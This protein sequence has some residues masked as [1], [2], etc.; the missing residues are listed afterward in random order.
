M[1]VFIRKETKNDIS[2]INQLNREAFGGE[3]EPKL[4]KLLRKRNELLVSL[5]AFDGDTVVGHTCASPVKIDG[6]DCSVAGIG[7]LAVIESHRCRGIGAMLMEEII[8]KLRATGITA[9]VLLGNPSYYPRFGFIS[10]TQFDLQNEYGASDA[11]MAIELKED[12]LNNISG[13]VQ[14]VAAFAECDA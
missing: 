11:F 2:A 1:T 6:E 4:V 12:A 5:V 9:A 7:P 14:Y 8:S 10:G 3:V 13:M